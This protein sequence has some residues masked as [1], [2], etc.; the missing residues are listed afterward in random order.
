MY[1]SER[2]AGA[3]VKGSIGALL[4]ALVGALPWI[5]IYA[6]GYISGYAAA[7]IS[8]TARIGYTLLRGGKGKAAYVIVILA[9]I[10]GLALGLLGTISMDIVINHETGLKGSLSLF[11]DLMNNHAAFRRDVILNTILGT[12]FMAAG[13]IYTLVE[14]RGQSKNN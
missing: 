12:V 10:I 2:E 5:I 11:V 14:I 6:M 1:G 9:S 13:L 4:G 7:F 3:V 8:I